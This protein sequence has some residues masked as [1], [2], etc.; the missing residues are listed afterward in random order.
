M[1]S[2]KASKGKGKSSKSKKSKKA[3]ANSSSWMPQP[4][5]I[6]LKLDLKLD[7]GIDNMVSW[8]SAFVEAPSV[9]LLTSNAHINGGGGGMK[10]D[11]IQHGQGVKT[12]PTECVRA[13]MGTSTTLNGS[14]TIVARISQN[15]RWQMFLGWGSTYPGHLLPTDPEPFTTEDLLINL[16]QPNKPMTSDDTPPNE[17]WDPPDGFEWAPNSSWCLVSV[18]DSSSKWIG[19]KDDEKWI[20]SSDIWLLP[21][22]GTDPDASTFARRRLWERRLEIYTPKARA[23][24]VVDLTEGAGIGLSSSLHVIRVFP[25]SHAAAQGV[26]PGARVVSIAGV[27]VET[28]DEFKTHIQKCRDRGDGKCTVEYEPDP[29]TLNKMMEAEQLSQDLASKSSITTKAEH[30]EMKKPVPSSSTTSTSLS[31]RAEQ[32]EPSPPEPPVPTS[33][34]PKPVKQKSVS[35]QSPNKPRKSIV[36]IESEQESRRLWEET[37]KNVL[38]ARKS[39]ASINNN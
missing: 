3:E 16:I 27:V 14:H 1:S 39:S 18:A 5:Q 31:Q 2:K 17:T 8:V 30:I 28:L 6:D 32:T 9:P 15:E 10:R 12:L 38:K 21:Q 23:S 22:H 35:F 24:F 19:Q 33:S 4:P 20:Y 37:K 29:E 26:L 36:A 13:G 34:L 25:K 7:Q 11:D